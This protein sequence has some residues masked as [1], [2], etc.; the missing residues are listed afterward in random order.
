MVG[1]V[2][3]LALCTGAAAAEEQPLRAGVTEFEVKNDIGVENAG[4]IIPELLVAKLKEAGR[5]NLSE[6]ILLQ[7][8][9][10]EQQLQ[11]SGLTEE[12]TVSEVGKVYN[13]DAVVSGS[14][15]Q[16]GGTIRVSGRLIH[17]E[18][19][20][21]LEA[22]TVKFREI[23]TL[24]NE[25][26]NLAYQLSGWSAAEYR[27]KALR[28]RMSRSRYGVRLGT[29]YQFNSSDAGPSGISAP[30]SVGFFFHSLHFDA[31]LLG[32][33]PHITSDS[34]HLTVAAH[35]NPFLHF[36][37]ALAGSYMYDGLAAESGVTAEYIS[38]MAG[39]N[40]RANEVLRTRLCIGP[41]LSGTLNGEQFD[42][43]YGVLGLASAL[44]S[45]EYSVSRAFSLQL[46]YLM[47]SGETVA[48]EADLASNYLTLMGTYSFS[49]R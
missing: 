20:K 45:L 29:A 17:T 44:F 32:N 23:D 1:L 2:V 11:M 35:Y 34:S 22:A 30:L 6:R 4:V 43:Y 36:G 42:M 41:T 19:G 27:R 33:I 8:A 49:I 21:I 40:F 5:Y 48:P 47:Q 26:R 9:L 13:L 14:A 31:E 15:M 24:E 39:I 7:K 10:E 3:G 16:V 46:L 18:T 25:L 28:E 37:L 38:L 12:D